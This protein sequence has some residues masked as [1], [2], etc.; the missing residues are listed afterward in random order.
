MVNYSPVELNTTFGALSDPTRRAIIE[1]L[2]T[3][4]ATIGELASPFNISLP[5]VSRHI[6]ILE[7]AGLLIR[8]KVGR[9]HYC[10][11]G[12]DPLQDAADWLENYR[13]F[14]EGQLDALADFLES[15]D[16]EKGAMNGS[17]HN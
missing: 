2:S 7:N 10:Q 17:N 8:R 16:E 11:L 4:E 15:E 9:V 12:S 5:A 1:Q 3:G 14:W 13:Q 6:R